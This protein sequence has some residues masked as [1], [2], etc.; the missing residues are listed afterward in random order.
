VIQRWTFTL[1]DLAAQ[2]T[3][4]DWMTKISLQKSGTPDF[5]SF[6]SQILVGSLPF[7]YEALKLMYLVLN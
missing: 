1:D 2:P 7:V 6:K 5:R 3:L 4:D